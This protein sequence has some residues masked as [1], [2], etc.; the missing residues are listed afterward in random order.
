MSEAGRLLLWG[1]GGALLGVVVFWLAVFGMIL[2]IE[3]F[4][5]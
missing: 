4:D 1:L 2:L 3:R 5:R